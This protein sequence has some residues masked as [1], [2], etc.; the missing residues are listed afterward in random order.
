[1]PER[2]P[3]T[4]AFGSIHTE[5]IAHRNDVLVLVVVLSVSVCYVCFVTIGV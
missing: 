3:K 5:F 1:M 4:C 2:A